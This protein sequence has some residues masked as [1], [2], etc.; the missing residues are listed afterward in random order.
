MDKQGE[1]TLGSLLTRYFLLLNRPK[2]VLYFES[3]PFK[4]DSDS[5]VEKEKQQ[6]I[7]PLGFIDFANVISIDEKDKTSILIKTHTRV[8]YLKCNNELD[9]SEWLKALREILEAFMMEPNLLSTIGDDV[10]ENFELDDEVFEMVLP[11]EE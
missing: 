5:V 10:F 6:K 2:G 1:N 9:C 3:N 7:K 11:H 8:Y 4:Q